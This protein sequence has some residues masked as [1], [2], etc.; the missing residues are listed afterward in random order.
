MAFVA[1]GRVLTSMATQYTRKTLP[2]QAKPGSA[3]LAVQD[4]DRPSHRPRVG[5]HNLAVPGSTK[6]AQV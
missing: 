3:D 6:P 4:L 5:R 2:D 1:S